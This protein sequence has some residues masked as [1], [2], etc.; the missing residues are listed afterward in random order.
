[1]YIYIYIYI[2]ICIYQFRNGGVDDKARIQP[3]LPAIQK[4]IS[5]VLLPQ[6]EVRLCMNDYDV[7]INIY[8]YI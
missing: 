4:W 1:M 2:Y 5:S 7:D 8:I 3:N 6:Q